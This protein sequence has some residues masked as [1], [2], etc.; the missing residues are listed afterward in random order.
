MNYREQ[1]LQYIPAILQS[2]KKLDPIKVVLFG[3]IT[4]NESSQDSDIDLLVVL[5]DKNI[6]A[7]YEDKM[8]IRLKVR[9]TIRE[10]NRKIP[11]DLF[12]YT[13]PEYEAF[14]EKNNSFCKE[15]HEFGNILYEKSS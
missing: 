8:Q 11:I 14:L 6:P 5:N 2:L 15:I 1:L 12:V 4:K 3:S 7:S 9:K 10:I 13:I